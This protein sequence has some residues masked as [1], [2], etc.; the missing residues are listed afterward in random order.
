MPELLFEIGSEE[1]PARFVDPALAALKDG[2]VAAAAEARLSHGAVAVFGTPRRI[3]ILVRELAA[4][5]EAAQKRLTGPS[6]RAAFD[7]QGAPTVAATKFAASVGRSVD[8]LTRVTTPKGE[9]LA[10]ELNE[11]GLPARELLPELLLKVL[12]Q[13]RFPKAM[14]WGEGDVTYGRPLRWIVALYDG[15]VVP[16]AYGDIESGRETRGHRFHAPAPFSLSKPADYEAALL[17]AHVVA[18]PQRRRSLLTKLLAEK[19]ALAKAQ[20]VEDEDLLAQVVNLVEEPH[21]VLGSF[22]ERHL[23]LPREVLIQEMKT[24]QRYFALT[25]SAGRLLPRFIAVSNTAVRDEQVSVAGY[26][27]VLAARLTDARFFFDEDRTMPL[28]ERAKRLARRTYFAPLGSMADKSARIGALAVKLAQL[29]GCEESATPII[30]R[31]SPLAKADLESGMVGEFPELQ[32]IMGREYALHDG[33]SS[34]VATAIAEHYLPRHAGD[35]LPSTDAGALIGLADRFDSLVGLF[36]LGKRPTGAKDEAGLRRACLGAIHIILSRGYRLSLASAL[37]ESQALYTDAFGRLRKPP[38]RLTSDLL[39][40][41]RGRLDVLFAARARADLVAA[42]LAAGA[43]D[44]LA[45]ERRLTALLGFSEHTAFPQLVQT[46]KRIR[47]IL[48]KSKASELLEA[49]DPALLEAGAEREFAAAVAACEPTVKAAMRDERYAEAFL[50]LA[51]LAAPVAAFFEAVLV[52]AEDPRLR[53]NRLRLLA[54][55]QRL[56]DG[57][58]VL[59]E[60]Q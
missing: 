42:I 5:T 21:P 10:A 18:D 28:I 49:P 12:K 36:A 30:L 22:A 55:A 23:D 32:G 44:I 34:E 19:A 43:D 3:A 29:V 52:M 14:R 37:N 41:F 17:K 46:F 15:E 31:S 47:N 35:A 53:N 20:V 33:E 6:L 50:A 40:F 39:E 25:D 13:I 59:S 45:A 51:S 54:Q 38:Q 26:E 2:F 4:S 8:E 1:L 7:A 60:V 27:R 16:L 58:V 48:E 57:L 9:Y 24:H 56:L 11:P